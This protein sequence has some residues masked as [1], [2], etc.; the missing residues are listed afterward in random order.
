MSRRAPELTSPTPRDLL[1]PIA[2]R[3]RYIGRPFEI[4]QLGVRPGWPPRPRQERELCGGVLAFPAPSPSAVTGL[5]IMP[6]TNI[7]RKTS[8]FDRPFGVADLDRATFAY[9]L[10]KERFERWE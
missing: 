9:S 1:F 10:K 3:E 8:C 5:G 6:L 4:L 7:E 2:N